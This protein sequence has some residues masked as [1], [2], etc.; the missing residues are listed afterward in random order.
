MKKRFAL[1]LA[2]ILILNLFGCASTTDASPKYRQN[3]DTTAST[4]PS[5]TA[6]TG[7]VAQDAPPTEAPTV[8]EAT[9]VPETTEAMETTEAII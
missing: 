4:V 2:L 9:E 5:V 6:P 8:T 7:A 3:S 1:F